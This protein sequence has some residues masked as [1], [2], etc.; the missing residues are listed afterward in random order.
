VSTA[1]DTPTD[2]LEGAYALLARQYVNDN[3]MFVSD[4][5]SG[6]SNSET[7]HM[8]SDLAYTRSAGGDSA[9]QFAIGAGARTGPGGLFVLMYGPSLGNEPASRWLMS[10]G[11]FL[12]LGRV[13]VS[14]AIVFSEEQ[15][16][17]RGYFT[18]LPIYGFSVEG[19]ATY[20]TFDQFED[21]STVATAGLATVFGG[22]KV[23]VVG[24]VGTTLDKAFGHLDS[25]WSTSLAHIL[26]NSLMPMAKSGS[27]LFDVKVRARHRSGGAGVFDKTGVETF[28]SWHLVK[29]QGY[30][31]SM[32]AFVGLSYQRSGLLLRCSRSL[33]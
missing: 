25:T 24:R 21:S 18:H 3:I 15:Y 23:P 10:S 26:G 17:V 31:E 29:S 19:G 30:V 13:V 1:E 16:A 22:L 8:I 6:L 27:Y 9:F 7:M 5:L 12:H 33:I 2:P 20:G 32:Y 14:A 28:L 4:P 11:G